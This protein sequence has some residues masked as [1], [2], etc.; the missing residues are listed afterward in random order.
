[1]GDCPDCRCAIFAAS[2]STQCTRCPASARHTPV[3]NPTYPVPMTAIR[4]QDASAPRLSRQ[5]F[6]RPVNLVQVTNQ[7]PCTVRRRM[8]TQ[9]AFPRANPEQAALRL[10]HLAQVTEDV[11]STAREEDLA[12]RLEKLVDSGPDV[13][14]DG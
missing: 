10:A 6:L 7:G 9:H 1:M 2:T 12:A 8:R 4:I 3:T 14:D 11:V 13:A 5:C